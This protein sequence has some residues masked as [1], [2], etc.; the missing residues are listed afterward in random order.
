MFVPGLCCCMGFSL[1][2][3]SR[4]YSLVAV[5]GLLIA[6]ASPVGR[7]WALGSLGFSSCGSWALEYRLNSC[8]PWV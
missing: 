7:S 1:V 8:G 5:H 2:A 4:G 3:G 6:V